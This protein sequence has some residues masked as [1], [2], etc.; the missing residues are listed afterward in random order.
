MPPDRMFDTVF[1]NRGRPVFSQYPDEVKRRLK[2]PHSEDWVRVHV[3]ETGAVVTVAEYLYQV[4]YIEIMEM[5]REILRKHDLALY[6]R[7]PERLDIYLESAARKI[8]ERA[9]K[10]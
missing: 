1:D 7:S 5:L 2:A 4:K 6:R 3:S 9:H 10:N 8:I